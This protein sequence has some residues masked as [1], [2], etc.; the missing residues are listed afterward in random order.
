MPGAADQAGAVVEKLVGLPLQ[1]NAAVR[2]AVAVHEH[3]AVLAHGKHLQLINDKA[4]AVSFG[5]LM[6]G[7]QTNHRYLQAR[8]GIIPYRPGDGKG[9]ASL[10]EWAQISQIRLKA[11]WRPGWE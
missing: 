7:A 9:H 10:R 5:K 8:A 3:V 1:R 2:A 6:R 11:A 4:P